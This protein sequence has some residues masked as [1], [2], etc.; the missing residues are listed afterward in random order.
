MQ[1]AI[2]IVVAACLLTG[3][4]FAQG[5]ELEG[6]LRKVKETGTLTIGYRDSSVPLSYLDDRLR[7]RFKTSSGV[8]KLS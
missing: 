7:V 2:K 8:T 6:T 5:Q 3:T 4:S 1:Q